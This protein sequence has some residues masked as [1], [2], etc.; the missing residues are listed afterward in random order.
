MK[1]R[2]YGMTALFL[3]F[4]VG[5]VWANLLEDGQFVS[6]IKSYPDSDTS[7]WFTLHEEGVWSVE[8]DDSR[9]FDP[10]GQS[11][12]INRWRGGV[13]VIQNTG[14]KVEFSHDYS[15][16]LQMMTGDP[17]TNAAHTASPGIWVTISS[18][19]DPRGPYIYRKQF[20]WEKTTFEHGRWE[21]CA[22]LIAAQ[23]LSS[24]V[25]EYMQLRI[26]KPSA[27]TSHTIW[28]D[29]VQLSSRDNGEGMVSHC[30]LLNH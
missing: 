20:F 26:V 15:V 16:S 1:K 30:G 22:G 4:T 14:T 23:D 5:G 11:I 19:K 27:K 29:D 8:M 2:V 13:N 6:E 7:P 10:G 25:G 28:I 12:K 9:S 3:M 17:S 18:A 21:T 24:F